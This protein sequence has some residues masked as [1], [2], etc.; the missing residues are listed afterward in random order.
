MNEYEHFRP[1]LE[2]MLSDGSIGNYIEGRVAGR[3]TDPPV[4]DRCSEVPE[5]ILLYF[6]GKRGQEQGRRYYPNEL[7]GTARNLLRE[8]GEDPKKAQDG[9]FGWGLAFFLGMAEDKESNPIAAELLLRNGRPFVS[10]PY[11]SKKTEHGL[12]KLAIPF[13][14]NDSNSDQVHRLL[15]AYIQNPGTTPDF[16]QLAETNLLE[17]DYKTGLSMLAE[18]MD[19]VPV[20]A[21]FGIAWELVVEHDTLTLARDLCQ[22]LDSKHLD[23]FMQAITRLSG[24]FSDKK[25]QAFRHEMQKLRSVP[26]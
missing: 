12:L 10:A 9:E 20:P 7:L 18:T 25:S 16:A 19:L 4:C 5:E 14:V 17:I 22:T 6:S 23:Y 1:R 11:F 21:H 2:A 15:L 13:P 8:L 3:I 24:D 26:S